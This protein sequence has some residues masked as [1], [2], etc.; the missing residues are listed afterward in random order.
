VPTPTQTPDPRRP[1][2]EYG[3]VLCDRAGKPRWHREGLDPE[4]PLH[5]MFQSK[6]G[7]HDRAPTVG[8][9]FRR[10]VEEC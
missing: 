3:C 6:H 7:W 5:L 10:L 8:E 4:Y 1:V 2:R 9:V